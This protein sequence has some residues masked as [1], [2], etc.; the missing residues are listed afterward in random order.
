MTII[1]EALL[2]V[3]LLAGPYA[4]AILGYVWWKGKSDE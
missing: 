3:L 2:E 4:V 1:I